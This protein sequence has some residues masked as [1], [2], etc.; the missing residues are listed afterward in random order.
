MDIPKRLGN[1][2][3]TAKM[4]PF[5]GISTIGDGFYLICTNFVGFFVIKNT[6]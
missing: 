4:S 1:N 5:V 6:F 2:I 3:F